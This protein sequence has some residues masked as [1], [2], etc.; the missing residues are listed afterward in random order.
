MS[1]L[2]FNKIFAAVLVAGII[3]MVGGFIA[4]IAVHPEELEENAYKIE[5]TDTGPA[6]AT[7]PVGPEPILALLADA[8]VEKG[9]K[10]AKKCIA[11]HSFDKGGAN[12][13]G[14]NLYGIVNA[15][16]AAVDGYSYSDALAAEGGTWDYAALNH[17]LWDPKDMI[18][19]TKM[20][21]AGLSKPK[22]RAA[23]IAY[24]R[25]QADSPAPLPT[26]DEIA[27]EMPEEEP[28]AEEEAAA[29]D[30]GE[31]AEADAE[32]TE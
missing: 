10:V 6:V 14:P 11:C 1:D 17:W 9:Q 7:G 21:F 27:A 15:P 20:N 2:E 16:L 18:S 12:K 8:D 5:V 19:G 25:S 23:V 4:K 26:A 3:A 24:M 22:D 30:A 28:A 29:D 31:G 13:T 32:T